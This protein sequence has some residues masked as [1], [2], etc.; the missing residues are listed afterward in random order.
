MKCRR[1]HARKTV[2]IP[3]IDVSITQLPSI[4]DFSLQGKHDPKKS[5]IS[6]YYCSVRKCRFRR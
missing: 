1:D 4:S 3:R 5:L 6:N 2:D